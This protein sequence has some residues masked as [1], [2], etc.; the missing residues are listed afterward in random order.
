MDVTNKVVL[1][2]GAARGMGAN[3]AR[4]FAAAGAKV[5]VA[6]ILEAEAAKLAAD[7][8]ADRAISVKLDVRSAADW[9]K[10]VAAA[11][12]RFGRL[13][14]L[15]NNAGILRFTDIETC[16]DEDWSAVIDI[17]LGGV[18]KGIRAAIPAM[19][20]AGGGSIV[21]IS[22]TAG[23]KG[24]GGCPHYISSKFA[25]RGLT[26]AAAIEL[27][28]FNIRVNSVHPG[29]IDTDMVAGLYPNFKHVP[30]N[31][32]GQPDEISKL[33]MFLASDAASFSTAAEFVADGG[34]TGGMPN[35][36]S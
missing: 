21:N 22:S 24:F 20:A 26:K 4:A 2:S 18:F 3:E 8:G 28:P 1:I 7:L 32:L 29:N 11:V 25:V 36:F 30:M 17:N 13:D 33:V 23:L 16:T 15:V 5:V 12:D 27:A 31:R 34:E 35:L 10:A 6:D 19:K 9:S 14:V